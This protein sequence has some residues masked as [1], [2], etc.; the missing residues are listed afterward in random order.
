MIA[1]N[2]KQVGSVLA[3]N[4]AEAARADGHDQG[5]PP[6]AE[7]A[8]MPETGLVV[9]ETGEVDQDLEAAQIQI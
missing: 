8:M 3:V 4:L 6:E 2:G 9:V 7:M 5:I 1:D